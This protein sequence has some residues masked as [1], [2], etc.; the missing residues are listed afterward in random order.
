M[1]TVEYPNEH[2]QGEWWKENAQMKSVLNSTTFPSIN[3]GVVQGAVEFGEYTRVGIIRDINRKRISRWNLAG[4]FSDG[5]IKARLN[6]ISLSFPDTDPD[7]KGDDS[8][9]MEGEYEGESEDEVG[10]NANGTGTGK[11]PGEG[12]Q[13]EMQRGG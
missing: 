7:G 6:D 11:F 1:L 5:L 8:E 4:R 12:L 3:Q 13:R 2:V 10:R 9:Q